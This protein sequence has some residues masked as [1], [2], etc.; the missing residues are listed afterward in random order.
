MAFDETQLAVL[1]QDKAS[2]GVVYSAVMCG[3]DE[4][5]PGIQVLQRQYEWQTCPS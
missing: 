1:R 5:L 3:Q 2:S 4:S